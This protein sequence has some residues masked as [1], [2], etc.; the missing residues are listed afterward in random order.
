[1]KRKIQKLIS[2]LCV[3]VMAVSMGA[4]SAFAAEPEIMPRDTND[5]TKTFI[6]NVSNNQTDYSDLARKDDNTNVY[7]KAK[8]YTLPAGGFT[9]QTEYQSV[10]GIRNASTGQYRISD[11]QAHSIRSDNAYITGDINLTGKNV[12]IVARYQGMSYN[13][14]DVTVLWSPDTYGN[15]PPL[16]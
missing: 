12:R 3:A 1:M 16:N 9:A 8:A 14:G 4:V 2:I 5:R 15:V 6:F 7:I 10:W 13:H 11:Y